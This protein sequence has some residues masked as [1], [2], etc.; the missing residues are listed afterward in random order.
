VDKETNTETYKKR[1]HRE[2]FRKK[3]RKKQKMFKS[4]S[5]HWGKKEKMIKQT[6][7]KT[8]R[9]TIV[10]TKRCCKTRKEEKIQ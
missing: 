6:S 1:M 9:M 3:D 10:K 8:D 5:R 7:W 2:L 4:W